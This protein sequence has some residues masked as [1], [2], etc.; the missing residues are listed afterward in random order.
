MRTILIIIRKE[1]I[2]IFRD[3]TMLPLIF[4]MPIIQLLILVNAATLDMRDID[5]YVV[6][7]DMSDVSRSLVN[8]FEASPF[9]E[10]HEQSFSMQKAE[11]SLKNN[12]CEVILKIPQNFEKSLITE[13]KSSVQLLI[14]A[15]D[16]S[17]AGL[18]NV[19]SNRVIARFNKDVIID[20][21]NFSPPLQNEQIN[22]SSSFWYNPS[23]NY[24]TYMFPGILVILVTAIGMFLTA[25]NLV[26]E[27]EMGT[28]EQINVTP[29][30]KYQFI[31]GKL[32]PMWIIALFELGFGL[33]IG[34][35]MYH[36]PIVGSVSTVFIFAA[37]YL[38]LMLAFGLFIST[39]SET[40]QQV[41]FIAFFFLL[42]FILMSGIF[43]PVESMPDWAIKA[44]IINPIASFMRVI[45]M[46]LLK[47][48]TLA[49][50]SYEM[51]YLAIYA[52][53]MLGLAVYRYRK[54]S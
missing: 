42:V 7:S 54:I 39:I 43:T 48:S 14:N 13:G 23:L 2:Q 37:L 28:I 21:I 47:G 53:I 52:S 30:Q 29:I 10:L 9:F 1:F 20:M 40:Q 27:K 41:M 45:R 5:L 33:A 38:V 11:K 8:R 31:I 17:S 18:I 46:V 25:L 49:D 51:K 26:R 6:D 36:I 32:V 34:E 22:V 12:T 15:I 44:N 4:L 24:K 16:G 19:Y 35:F 3:K 50:I